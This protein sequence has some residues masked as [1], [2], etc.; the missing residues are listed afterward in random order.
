MLVSGWLSESLFLLISCIVVMLVIGLVIEK[1]WN[2]LLGVS[3]LVLVKFL[4]F[5]IVYWVDWFGKLRL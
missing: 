1:M 3:M 5:L 2:R 4:V